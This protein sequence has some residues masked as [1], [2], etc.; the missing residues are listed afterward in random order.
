MLKDNVY[1]LNPA[2]GSIDSGAGWMADFRHQKDNENLDWE[3]WGGETLI[4][5]VKLNNDF[6][7]LETIKNLMDDEIRE[8]LHSYNF[9]ED[10]DFLNAYVIAH[11]I[12]FNEQ[13]KV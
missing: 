11:K 7:E 10:Q 8:E 2:T 3:E 5:V 12:K 13:F 4:Q 9:S 1:Y 6:Y